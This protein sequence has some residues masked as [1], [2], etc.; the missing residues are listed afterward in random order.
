MQ[1]GKNY[2]WPVI[3]GDRNASG[4]EPPVIQSGT[5]TWAPSG[6]AFWNGSIFFGALRGQSLF[7]VQIND[8]P[9]SLQRHL[10]RSFGRIRDVVVGPDGLLYITTSNRDGRGVPT[11]DDDRIIRI[12]PRKL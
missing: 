10:N 2:G 1:P 7:Q 4:M 9:L 3:R 5:D 11:P 6:A 8:Q 12:N